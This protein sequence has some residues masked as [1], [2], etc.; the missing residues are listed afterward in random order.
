VVVVIWDGQIGDQ[1]A[2]IPD[3]RFLR[4]RLEI[5]GFE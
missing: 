1:W 5:I 3:V 2:L 4:S